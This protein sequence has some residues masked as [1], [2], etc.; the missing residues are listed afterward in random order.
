MARGQLL[1]DVAWLVYTLWWTN[2]AMENPPIMDAF[3]G[4][5]LKKW[6]FSM[7]RLVHQKV[8]D[9]TVLIGI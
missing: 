1:V 8:Y 2:R 7:A 6:L 9:Y 3:P 4:L 5:S